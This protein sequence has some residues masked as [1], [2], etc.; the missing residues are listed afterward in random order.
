M[1]NSQDLKYITKTVTPPGIGPGTTSM[2]E[3]LSWTLVT[4]ALSLSCPFHLVIPIAPGAVPLP[5][6]SAP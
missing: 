4:Q 3:L 1:K 2:S 5:C 6:V